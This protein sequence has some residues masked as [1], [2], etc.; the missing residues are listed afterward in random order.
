VPQFAESIGS[1]GQQVRGVCYLAA[2][3]CQHRVR[4]QQCAL[5]STTAG[6]CCRSSPGEEAAVGVH[7]HTV[8][9]ACTRTTQPSSS[10]ASSSHTPLSLC[11]FSLPVL[12]SPCLPLAFPLPPLPCNP[13]LQITILRQDVVVKEMPPPEVVAPSNPQKPID[14][15]A[16][17]A[18][19]LL[20]RQ[21][22]CTLRVRQGQ[23]PRL[24]ELLF[25]AAQPRGRAAAAA[26]AAVGAAAVGAGVDGAAAEVSPRVT[27]ERVKE[28]R[29]ALKPRELAHLQNL[30]LWGWLLVHCTC[31]CGGV[32]D[33]TGF[34]GVG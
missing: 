3:W 16:A 20:A 21:R 33:H 31:A 7:C 28:A 30:R 8:C 5:H 15:A 14:P 17:A 24:T 34:R 12:A 23:L 25:K 6:D 27:E 2:G 11:L 1:N 18:A 22:R 10:P 32:L 29:Q 4:R 19:A 26:A 9:G 13:V